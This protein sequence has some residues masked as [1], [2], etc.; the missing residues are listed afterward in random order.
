MTKA[1]EERLIKL[2]EECAETIQIGT[3]I[4]QYGY[5]EH[6]PGDKYNNRERLE[7]EL[8]DIMYWYS[9]MVTSGDVNVA[10]ILN[11]E[12][13]RKKHEKAMKYTQYQPESEWKPE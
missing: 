9:N 7:N 5:E 6:Y 2:M 12:L 1:E 3:K 13:M 4:L 8:R 10:T 11:G